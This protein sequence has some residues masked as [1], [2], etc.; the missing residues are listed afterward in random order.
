MYKLNSVLIVSFVYIFPLSWLLNPYIGNLQSRFLLTILLIALTFFLNKG[1]LNKRFIIIYSFFLGLILINIILTSYDEYVIADAIN[2]LVLLFIPAYILLQERVLYEDLFHTWFRFALS[3]TLLIPIYF[4]LLNNNYINYMDLA[5][6]N[7]LN[8]IV[9]SYFYFKLERN[10]SISLIFLFINLIIST[11]FGSRMIAI[12]SFVII[13]FSMVYFKRKSFRY[14][15]ILVLLIFSGILF[16][17]N[18]NNI[19]FYLSDK[20]NKYGINSR[21]LNLLIEQ[22]SK[23]DGEIYLSGREQIYTTVTSYLDKKG[24]FPSGISVARSITNGDF[25]HAHN[26]FLE[27][28]LIFGYLFGLILIVMFVFRV[29][30]IFKKRKTLQD[31]Y[32]IDLL[33]LLI[34]SFFIRSL[35]GTYFLSDSLFLI[36]LALLFTTNNKAR[37]I[38]IYTEQT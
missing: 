26:F 34:V 22:L 5:Y 17:N 10:E 13:L 9:F 20:L 32:K 37:E 23:K 1:I 6:L 7:H 21:N 25:Y 11:I 15:F 31:Y 30:F 2:F 8:I 3:F 28:F 16:F 24:F 18:L 35:T 12:A 38:Y 27:L 14:Y 4:S 29:W 33:L 36:S 19:L